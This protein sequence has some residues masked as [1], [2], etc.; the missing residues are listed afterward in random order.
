VIITIEK[1]RGGYIIRT[2][3]EDADSTDDI[4]VIADT[5]SVH[6]TRDMLWTIVETL[7]EQGSKYDK[8]RI[9]ISIEPGSKWI[10]P[11]EAKTFP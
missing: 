11:E 6:A 1:A 3:A 2:P 4:E 10:A 9:Q 8:E 5:N 7:G